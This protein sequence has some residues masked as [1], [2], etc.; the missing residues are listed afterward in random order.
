MQSTSKDRC[1]NRD[2][3]GFTLI[4]L[5]VGLVLGLLTVLVITQVMSLSEGKKRT[6]TMGG[7]A[8]VNG[9][10]S[11][12]TL[13]RDIQQA[14]Y[15]AAASPDAL[16]CAVSRQFD[17]SGTVSKF[18]LAPVVIT[19]GASGAP[20]TITILQARTTNFSTPIVL[21][22][23]HLQTDDHFTVSSSLNTV[24]GNLMIAVPKTQSANI[25]CSLFSATTDT[26]SATK[27]LGITNVPH[28]VG[29]AALAKWNQNG[30]FPTTGYEA[31]SYLLNMGAMV[32]RTYSIDQLSLRSDDFTQTSTAVT[33]SILYPQ[34]VNLQAF[35][36]KDT[37]GDGI[38]DTYDNATPT[39][40]AG[41]QQVLSIRLALVA[42]SNQY[43]KDLVTTANPLWDVGA[44]A[45]FGG[46][47]P[48]TC[49]GASKCI[50][51][52]VDQ[53]PDWQH[54][55]YRVYDTIVPLRNVIWNS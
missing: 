46:T 8:Q 40:S 42:R 20:D 39:T 17:T 36:G 26:S 7:D 44:T 3:C 53:V 54:Y 48:A 9:S 27:T 32:L 50:S 21:T 2:Q 35:Y 34:I 13:Q 23:N 15:G 49:N 22:G 25:G 18:T 11:M 5:M 16:G 24:A 31:G 1:A 10:L 4:E 43:E 33:T 51:L 37:D 19:D 55:R 47:T 28:V 38:V 52:K 12:F 41:W 6:I 14:G 45:T 29:T 30:I